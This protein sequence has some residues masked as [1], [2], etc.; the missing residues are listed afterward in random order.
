MAAAAAAAAGAARAPPSVDDLLAA[1]VAYTH[2]LGLPEAEGRGGNLYYE[3]NQQ[4]RERSPDGRA[5]MMATWG[6]AVHYTLKALALLPPVEAT[7]FRGFAD[8]RDS[9]LVHYKQGRPIQWGA[10]TSTTTDVARARG[11]AQSAAAGVVFKITVLSGRDIG[12]L[13]FFR[14]ENEVLLS[15]AHKFIVASATGGYVDEQGYTTIDLL[16]IEGEWFV[17]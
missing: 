1:I 10:F 9:I 3:M 2:D 11:F 6:V 4:L 7:C 8:G 14:T 15:P 5:S 16:Q 12:P 17:S 13:S